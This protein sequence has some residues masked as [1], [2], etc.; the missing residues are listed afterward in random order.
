M[1]KNVY[2][3]YRRLK[4]TLGNL[5]QFPVSKTWQIVVFMINL[6]LP[7]TIVV[8]NPF[9]PDITI[10]IFIHYKPRHNSRLV[11]DEDD[12]LWFKN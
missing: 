6:F 4:V 12:L 9:K 1:K 11:V 7:N 3:R 5:S 10:V 2:I 8:F